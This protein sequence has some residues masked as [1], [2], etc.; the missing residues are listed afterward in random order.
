MCLKPMCMQLGLRFNNTF[1]VGQRER[2]R[3]VV[4]AGLGRGQTSIYF[5]F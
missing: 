4:K 1:V 2:E 3:E 5:D